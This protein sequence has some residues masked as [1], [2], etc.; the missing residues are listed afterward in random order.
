MVTLQG[1]LDLTAARRL[2][3]LLADLIDGQGNLEVVVD[4]MYVDAVEQ[5]VVDVLVQASDRMDRRGGTLV[6]ASP[7]PEVR[8]VLERT[9]LR[10]SPCTS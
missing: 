7:R 9:P 6:V 10:L 1:A 4:G 3:T 2:D 5:S 8:A